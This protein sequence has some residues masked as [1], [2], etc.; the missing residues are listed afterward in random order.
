M[1][2]PLT[3]IMGRSGLGKSFSIRNLNPETTVIFNTELKP[4]PFRGSNAFKN[5]YLEEPDRL[6]SYIS[7]VYSRDDIEVIVIDS[8]S[9][10]SEALMR[11]CRQNFKNYE[12]FNQYNSM[13]SNL[14]QLLKKSPKQVFLI[15]HEEVV[16]LPSGET[17]TSMKV[18]GKIWEGLLEKEAVIVMHCAMTADGEG[19]N[20]YYFETQ[21][22][23]ST[24]AKSPAE[25]FADFRIPN[26]LNLINEAIKEYYNDGSNT[27]GD[28]NNAEAGTDEGEAGA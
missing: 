22:N 16:N 4:L 13:I 7:Q 1:Y 26:D 5:V 20:Q 27:A 2:K 19:A 8:F 11:Q 21:S 10:W 23:G 28:N 3:I 14:M 25:M 9:A 15:G 12:I 24:N 17:I 6:F 18:Q